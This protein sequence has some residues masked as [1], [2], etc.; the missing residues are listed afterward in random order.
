MSIIDPKNL[1]G[2]LNLSNIAEAEQIGKLRQLGWK[3]SDN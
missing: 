1:Y 2:V 3:S